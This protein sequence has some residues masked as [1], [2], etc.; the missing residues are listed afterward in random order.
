[1]MAPVLGSVM[2]ALENNPSRKFTY[3]EM[4]F[5]HMW[6]EEQNEKMRKRV[7]KFVANGQL[8]FVNAG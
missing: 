4:A 8:E 5:F 3:V 6:W 2:D 7:R 1:L